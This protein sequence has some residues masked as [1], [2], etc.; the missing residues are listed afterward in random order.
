MSEV[1][2]REGGLLGSPFIGFSN[3]GFVYIYIPRRREGLA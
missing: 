2:S 3:N 1:A